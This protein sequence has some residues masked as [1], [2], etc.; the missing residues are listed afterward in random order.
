MYCPN[1]NN[2]CPDDAVFCKYCGTTLTGSTP[3]PAAPVQTPSGFRPDYPLKW[4]YFLI[5]FSLFAAA[6]MNALT[7]FQYL[8]ATVYMSEGLSTA[9]VELVYSM[10][11]ALEGID[12][13]YGLICIGVGVLAIITRMH[14]AK[15]KASGPKLLYILYACNCV[16]PLLYTCISF[17]AVPGSNLAEALPPTVA[18]A[19]G[20][21]IMLFANYVYFSRRQALFEY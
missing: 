19:I 14:L 12:K 13:T 7:G 15:F 5:Y 16:L 18:S 3:M 8:T 21:G 10:Y 11:P 20:P 1:C 17:S 6:V 4:Y 2:H 9:D